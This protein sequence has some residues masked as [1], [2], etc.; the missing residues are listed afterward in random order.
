[1]VTFASICGCWT[2]SPGWPGPCLLSKTA[3]AKCGISPSTRRASDS[4]SAA[5]QAMFTWQT[6]LGHHRSLNFGLRETGLPVDGEGTVRLWRVYKR[7]LVDFARTR[8]QPQGIGRR[9]AI[10]TAS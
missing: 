6:W 3:P 2:T 4:S 1:M 8:V 7:D 9:G 10:P 5:P